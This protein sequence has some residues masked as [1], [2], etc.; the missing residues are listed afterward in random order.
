MRPNVEE[1][2]K[3]ATEHS[4]LSGLNPRRR[5]TP[6][7]VSY[8]SRIDDVLRQ[9]SAETRVDLWRVIEDIRQERI[10]YDDAKAEITSVVERRQRLLRA[11][12]EVEAP[13][14]FAKV[15]ALL[16]KSL[17]LSISDD[18]AIGRWAEA[19][20]ARNTEPADHWW[21]VQTALSVRATKTK[22]AFLEQYNQLRRS[23]F[24]L[25]RLRIA[26]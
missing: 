9:F 7:A 24:G 17:R 25:R 19:T 11:V 2:K 13:A 23:L 26:Y 6:T 21:S 18:Q 15:H 22:A 12:E 1:G 16:T 5:T 3:K 4:A 8:V 10:G 14:P 20:F